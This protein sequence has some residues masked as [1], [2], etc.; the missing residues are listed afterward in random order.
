[1]AII[2]YKNNKDDEWLDEDFVDLT[3]NI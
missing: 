2:I 1:M 3:G